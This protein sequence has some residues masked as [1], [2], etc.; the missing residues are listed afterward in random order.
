MDQAGEDDEKLAAM[1]KVAAEAVDALDQ[2]DAAAIEGSEQ[3]A[4]FM[5]QVGKH[6]ARRV[7]RRSAAK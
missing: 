3:L 4:A 6:V 2:G 5:S 1:R 7:E